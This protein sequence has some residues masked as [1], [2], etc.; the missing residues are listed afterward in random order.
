M[1]DCR[2]TAKTAEQ[3]QVSKSRAIHCSGKLSM[4]QIG[5]IPPADIMST[6]MF[7]GMSTSVS[8]EAEDPDDLKAFRKRRSTLRG[9]SGLQQTRLCNGRSAV[10]EFQ[11]L[12]FRRFGARNPVQQTGFDLVQFSI[13][14]F[15][16]KKR[17][18]KVSNKMESLSS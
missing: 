6:G 3:C 8:G 11:T 1:D 13:A 17:F 14:F 5:A 2:M 9:V 12:N 18:S 16:V 4:Y 7:T 10:S 15:L